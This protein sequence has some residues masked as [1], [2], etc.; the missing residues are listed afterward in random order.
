MND[1]VNRLGKL[2]KEMLKKTDNEL[3]IDSEYTK[4]GILELLQGLKRNFDSADKEPRFRF[5]YI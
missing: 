1:I 2:W 5:N 4:S 3:G